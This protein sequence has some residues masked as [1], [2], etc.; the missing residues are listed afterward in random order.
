MDFIHF[1]RE[2]F[3]GFIGERGGDDSFYAGAARGISQ[4]A[5][6]NS[7]AGDDSKRGWDLHEARLTMQDVCAKPPQSKSQGPNPKP[8]ANLKRQKDQ[9]QKRRFIPRN[10]LLGNWGLFF[11]ISAAASC[12]GDA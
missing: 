2:A 12:V 4:Q 10:E 1:A 5:R 9:S 7:V 6:I 8:Q 3:V 11:G